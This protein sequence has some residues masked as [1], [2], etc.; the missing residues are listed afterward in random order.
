M[1]EWYTTAKDGNKIIMHEFVVMGGMKKPE[2]TIDKNGRITEDGDASGTVKQLDKFSIGG[3]KGYLMAL[4]DIES[5]GNKLQQRDEVVISC[6]G[7]LEATSRDRDDMA[8]F[9]ITINR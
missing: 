3:L 2:V 9:E 4:G 8:Q 7:V 6:V 5:Q 1:R